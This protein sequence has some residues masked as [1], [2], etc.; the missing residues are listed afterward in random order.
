MSGLFRAKPT[1]VGPLSAAL[2]ARRLQKWLGGNDARCLLHN[3]EQN[4]PHCNG[5][6]A[7]LM[8]TPAY[9]PWICPVL[10][11]HAKNEDN[12]EICPQVHAERLHARYNFPSDRYFYSGRSLHTEERRKRYDHWLVQEMY[13][14]E[15]TSPAPI[16]EPL[17]EDNLA[18]LVCFV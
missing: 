14:R 15:S 3:T 18:L 8:T 2:P 6:N 10:D 5:L 7:P 12:G 16:G 13:E 1:A 9:P 17:V 4:I 11:L